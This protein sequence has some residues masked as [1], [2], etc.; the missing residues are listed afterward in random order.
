METSNTPSSPPEYVFRITF[1][2]GIEEV[3]AVIN[4]VDGR[5]SCRYDIDRSRRFRGLEVVRVKTG[6]VVAWQN[7]DFYVI[8]GDTLVLH[9]PV[10][11]YTHKSFTITDGDLRKKSPLFGSTNVAHPLA[12][13]TQPSFMGK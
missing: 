11:Q 5:A 7:D 6:T 13:V 3:P 2:D 9:S 12:D 10:A 1:E 8:N 4:D